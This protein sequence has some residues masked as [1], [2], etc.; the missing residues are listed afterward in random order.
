MDRAGRQV[1]R[2]PLPADIPKPTGLEA[3][4]ATIPVSFNRVRRWHHSQPSY[5]PS[6]LFSI[7]SNL[8]RSTAF[9]A[10]SFSI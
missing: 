9:S 8:S 3:F 4:S 7:L 1:E 6:I 2:K 10:F 5:F